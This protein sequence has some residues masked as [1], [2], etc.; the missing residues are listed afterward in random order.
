LIFSGKSNLRQMAISA[1]FG[2]CLRVGG[3]RQ[4]CGF[5]Y[6]SGSEEA[7]SRG[8]SI[9]GLAGR[10][11]AGLEF[12]SG[13]SEVIDAESMDWAV[14]PPLAVRVRADFNAILAK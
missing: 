3:F 8:L 13:S 12:C 5:G 7:L 1:V 6:T 4:A 2:G 10:N 11:P 9:T 14:R